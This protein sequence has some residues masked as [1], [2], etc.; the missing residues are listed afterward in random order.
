[1]LHCSPHLIFDT[2]S[3]LDF[4]R[5]LIG[6]FK[7]EFSLYASLKLFFILSFVSLIIQRFKDHLLLSKAAAKRMVVAT[8]FF[9]GRLHNVPSSKRFKE[10]RSQSE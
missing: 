8:V 6:N 1:M 4:F 5:I 3:C 10:R 2:I 7:P 9:F